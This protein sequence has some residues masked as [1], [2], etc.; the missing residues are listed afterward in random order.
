M[1]QLFLFEAQIWLGP[2][3]LGVL[4]LAAGVAFSRRRNAS[5]F[6]LLLAAACYLL[7]YLLNDLQFR[8]L[9]TWSTMLDG[10]K[11]IAFEPTLRW[12]YLTI[13]VVGSVSGIAG[14]L[15]SL[16]TTSVTTARHGSMHSAGA[17][18]NIG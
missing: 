1:I 4:T 10:S 9:G 3:M 17:A 6:L 8:I 2:I 14:A 12:I 18:E 16:R 11:Y 15:L 7:G 13:Q 5:S